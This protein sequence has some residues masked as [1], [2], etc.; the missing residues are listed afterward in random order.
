MIDDLDADFHVRRS[1]GYWRTLTPSLCIKFHKVRHLLLVL[2]KNVVGAHR[3]DF[4]FAEE[5]SRRRRHLSAVSRMDRGDG[6]DQATRRKHALKRRE[7]GIGTL[8]PA[9]DMTIS[10]FIK[11]RWIRPFS[12][13]VVGRNHATKIFDQ[14]T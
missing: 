5:D 8:V 3:N 12:F 10:I 11:R 14:D 1:H 4:S 2:E 9:V 13:R 7:L 6:L